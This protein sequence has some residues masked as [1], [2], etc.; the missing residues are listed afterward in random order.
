MA[1]PA[2]V[3]VPH[4]LYYIELKGNGG[5]AIFNDVDDYD[6][7]G[8]CVATSLRRNRCRL[9]AFCWL[10]NRA[11]MAVEITDV[12][13]GRF[14]QHMTGQYARYLHGK[15]QRTGHLFEHHHRALLVQRSH[16]LLHL[17]RYIHR[18]PVRAGLV[19]S[20]GDYMWSGDRGYLR[21]ERIPWLT[22]HVAMEMLAHVRGSRTGTYRDWT[23]REDDPEIAC[24]FEHGRKDEPRAVGDDGFITEV[25]GH[26]LTAQPRVVLDDIIACVVR[27]QGVSLRFVLSRS[28]RR[29]D[30]LARALI[31]WKATQNGIATLTEVAA[32]LN[33]DPSTLWT[34]MERY[35]LSCPELFIDWKIGPTSTGPGEPSS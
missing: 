28:R 32:R 1:R 34:A 7:F 17:V 31:T 23:S 8:S 10:E 18:A 4:G 29:E 19:A 11:L 26:T 22:T 33:R 6:E 35:R 2:R 25:V 21:E 13:I 16:Y 14:V 12:R 27:K 24:L 3:H 15:Q 20:S 9:H 30:V 5:D